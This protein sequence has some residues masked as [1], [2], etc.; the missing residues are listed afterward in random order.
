MEKEFRYISNSN[1]IFL[2]LMGLG[3][4]VPSMMTAVSISEESRG[5]AL[6]AGVMWLLW[7]VI[8]WL[9]YVTSSLQG[10]FT[11]DNEA[12]DFKFFK[13][14]LHLRYEDI[15][16]ISFFN[17]PKHDRW[18]CLV[19]YD[20]QLV[21]TDKEENEHVIRQRV[22]M[23]YSSFDYPQGLPKEV[24]NAELTQIGNFLKSKLNSEEV[25]DTPETPEISDSV[26]YPNIADS[27]EMQEIQ[28]RMR[29]K[30][31]IKNI[32]IQQV[33]DFIEEYYKKN[34]I[35]T[36]TNDKTFYDDDD[37]TIRF[38]NISKLETNVNG[39]MI[40]DFTILDYVKNSYDPQNRYE[41][42]ENEWGILSFYFEKA[43]IL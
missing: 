23:E 13:G 35:L 12:C 4:F 43:E 9:C 16:K 27:P 22:S 20:I 40:P 41:L 37:V 26:M 7:L 38:E 24:Q 31:Y 32:E 42:V 5:L 28:N 39:L 30:K 33:Y 15:K 18:N 6:A 19:A 17:V 21:I 1:I 29:E 14:N 25:S 8:L 34:L 10:H 3:F 11:A 36:L 2:I